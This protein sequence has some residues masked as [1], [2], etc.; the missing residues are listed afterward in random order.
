MERGQAFSQPVLCTAIRS[1][2]TAGPTHQA[3]QAS[4]PCACESALVPHGTVAGASQTN[5]SSEKPQSGRLSR[6]TRMR[7]RSSC[8]NRSQKE[9]GSVEAAGTQTREP[10][11][12]VCAPSRLPPAGRILLGV[13]QH[14]LQWVFSLDVKRSPGM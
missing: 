6:T 12:K 2:P 10:T 1:Q 11:A 8:L 3:H 14:S 9:D 4:I 7:H 5:A 13:E